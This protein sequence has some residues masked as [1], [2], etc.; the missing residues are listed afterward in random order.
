[1]E[2]VCDG[3]PV[4]GEEAFLHNIICDAEVEEGIVLG[5]QEHALRE[6][7]PAQQGHE[8]NWEHP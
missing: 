8:Q 2:P 5:A 7:R 4:K 6:Y 1:M 3:Q